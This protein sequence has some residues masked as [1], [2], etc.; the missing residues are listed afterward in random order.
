MRVL[1]RPLHYIPVYSFERSP[2]GPQ[3]PQIRPRLLTVGHDVVIVSVLPQMYCEV[4]LLIL[5]TERQRIDIN[6]VP[7]YEERLE[8]RPSRLSG[9]VFTLEEVSRSVCRRLIDDH[10]I[11]PIYHTRTCRTNNILRFLSIGCFP[12]SHLRE[13]Y[14]V[15]VTSTARVRSFRRTN[16]DLTISLRHPFDCSRLSNTDKC[17]F[18]VI[19]LISDLM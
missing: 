7:C 12:Q 2:I 6:V 8:H 18:F 14:Q 1:S 10:C 3:F 5:G 15:I 19:V 16:L 4:S 11:R 17:F 9:I 13:M